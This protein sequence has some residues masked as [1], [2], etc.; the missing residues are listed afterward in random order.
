MNYQERI[1]DEP[2]RTLFE[3]DSFTFYRATFHHRGI[4]GTGF[5]SQY[6]IGENRYGNNDTTIDGRPVAI[7]Q[8]APNKWVIGPITIRDESLMRDLGPFA[9]L[10]EALV[11]FYLAVDFR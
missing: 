7:M 8:L 3:F 10:D 11:T 9:T 1:S 2:S 5:C 6:L 4:Q